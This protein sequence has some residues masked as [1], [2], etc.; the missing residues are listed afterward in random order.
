[1]LLITLA[2]DQH[3]DLPDAMRDP[4]RRRPPGADRAAERRQRWLTDT[5][6][7][8]ARGRGR[9]YE[10]PDERERGVDLGL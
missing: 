3:P 7:I 9:S 8:A 2:T 6:T 4:E 1:M 10:Q 5:H